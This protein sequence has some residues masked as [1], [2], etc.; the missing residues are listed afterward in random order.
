M[1]IW[2]L[3][4]KTRFEVCF[5]ILWSSLDKPRIITDQSERYMCHWSGQCA[6]L[7]DLAQNS[8]FPSVFQVLSISWSFS[9]V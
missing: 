1:L 4:S 8:L 7:A 6:A 3:G 5:D 2:C 9:L